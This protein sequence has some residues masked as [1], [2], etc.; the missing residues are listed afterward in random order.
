MPALVS[1]LRAVMA[2]GL[3]GGE[4]RDGEGSNLEG[5]IGF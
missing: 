5:A 3:A 2:A 4:W 1:A